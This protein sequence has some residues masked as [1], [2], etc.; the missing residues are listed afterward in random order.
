MTFTEG[1]GGH[2]DDCQAHQCSNLEQ[3]TQK[4]QKAMKMDN[5]LYCSTW[6]DFPVS[7]YSVVFQQK[8]LIL[9]ILELPKFSSICLFISFIFLILSPSASCSQT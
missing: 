9:P 1:D 7:G 5:I 4:S 2:D 3:Q 8:D 6:A